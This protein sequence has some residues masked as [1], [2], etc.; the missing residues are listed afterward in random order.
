MVAPKVVYTMNDP[1]EKPPEGLLL[2]GSHIRKL[3]PEQ[4][5]AIGDF[6]SRIFGIEVQAVYDI[7]QELGDAMLRQVIDDQEKRNPEPTTRTA[8]CNFAAAHSY[9][10]NRATSAWKELRWAHELPPEDPYP[11]IRYIG[12]PPER[13][14]PVVVDLW[15]VYER[16]K[17]S[18]IS[19]LT[20]GRPLD[21]GYDD[22]SAHFLAHLINERLEPEDP[23]EFK[24]LD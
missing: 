5:A 13:N 1:L 22:R 17:E 14:R 6:T 12:S 23:L 19:Q 2:S 10:Y 16:F 3:R 8:V 18:G 7:G 15:S 21:T 4:V 11:R 24:R 20:W 9:P